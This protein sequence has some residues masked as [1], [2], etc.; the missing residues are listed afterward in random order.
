[1]SRETWGWV[2]AALWL[3]I[4]GSLALWSVGLI[5]WTAALAVMAIVWVALVEAAP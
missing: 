2:T 3:E 1:M 4:A 5:H